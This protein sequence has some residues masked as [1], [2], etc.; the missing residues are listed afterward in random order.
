M[1]RAVGTASGEV[2]AVKLLPPDAADDD[3]GSFARELDILPSI[4]HPNVV[5]VVYAAREGPAG[6]YLMMEYLPD[7]TL[8]SWLDARRAGA[9]A[10]PVHEARDLMLQLAQ[11]ASAFQEIAVHRDIRPHNI[12]LDDGR[13]KLADFGIAKRAGAKTA[14][15]SFKGL[16]AP[17]YMAPESFTSE[18]NTYKMDVYAIG[19]VF[20]EI[21]TLQHPLVADVEPHDDSGWR[22]AHCFVVPRSMLEK[23]PDLPVPIASLI[24]RML[25]KNPAERPEWEVVIRVLS[26]EDID[27]PQDVEEV[28]RVATQQRRAVAV[29]MRQAVQVREEKME[30]EAAFWAACEDL[31]RKLDD[32]AR[33]LSRYDEE[34]D[35]TI[36][37]GPQHSRTYQF[38]HGAWLS[39]IFLNPDYRGQPAF[40]GYVLGAACL[41][42]ATDDG[43]SGNLLLIGERPEHTRGRWVGAVFSGMSEEIGGQSYNAKGHARH[44]AKIRERARVSSPAEVLEGADAPRDPLTWRGVSDGMQLRG[45]LASALEEK[46]SERV[47]RIDDVRSVFLS[48]VRA[49]L[50]L[51]PYEGMVQLPEETDVGTRYIVLPPKLG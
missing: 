48:L 51:P 1:Y 8:A 40:E 6:P 30:R 26:D 25:A 35:V 49:A 27:P 32:I 21:C 16:Q 29:S 31:A 33:E 4:R 38:T 5:R 39:C 47:H 14:K 36:M 50:S 44:E 22:K 43:P 34:L 46:G 10:V 7:G 45:V 12:L 23:R 17:E 28:L 11:G 24:D 15:K 41:V 3:D 13:P 20:S 2:V 18:P 37:P 9:A 19:L 42:V